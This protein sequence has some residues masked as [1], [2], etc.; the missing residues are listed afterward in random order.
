M[1]V[2]NLSAVIITITLEFEFDRKTTNQLCRRIKTGLNREVIIHETDIESALDLSSSM[3]VE[4]HYG[5]FAINL[6]A[7]FSC[8][9]DGGSIVC[10]APSATINH[11][12]KKF[13]NKKG[14]EY[15]G[16]VILGFDNLEVTNELLKDC[17]NWDGAGEGF[18]SSFASRFKLMSCHFVQ[19]IAYCYYIDFKDHQQF[20]ISTTH[21]KIP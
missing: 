3:Q 11:M 4:I 20:K 7:G 14:T 8:E 16:N 2:I 1:S 10:E 5:P 18:F 21:I 19:K 17:T 9:L 6:K 15:S 13:T 12:Y